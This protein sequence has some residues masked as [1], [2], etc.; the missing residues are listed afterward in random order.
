MRNQS[1]QN[2]A[3]IFFL[4]G[5]CIKFAVGISSG[6]TFSKAVITF[7]VSGDAA[8]QCGNVFAPFLHIL[9]AL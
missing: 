8:I 5:A 4:G 3:H 2:T 7:W 1:F 6:A 9:A